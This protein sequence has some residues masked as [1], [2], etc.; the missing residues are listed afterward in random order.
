MKFMMIPL[1][2]CRFHKWSSGKMALHEQSICP[3]SFDVIQSSSGLNNTPFLSFCVFVQNCKLAQ[4]S[5]Y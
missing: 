2:V 4:H 5:V 1:W 3:S